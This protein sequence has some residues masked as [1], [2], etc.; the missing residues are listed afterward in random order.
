MIIAKI[1][2]RALPVPNG[3]SA[4]IVLVSSNY[5]YKYISDKIGHIYGR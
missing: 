5:V 3:K 2:N 4:K 1:F